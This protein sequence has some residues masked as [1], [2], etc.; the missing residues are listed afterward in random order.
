MTHR[1]AG[2]IPRN[3][4]ML[5]GLRG[6]LAGVE[7]GSIRTKFVMVGV[8]LGAAG[9]IFFVTGARLFGLPALSARVLQ[10]AN[11]VAE[12]TFV[13]DLLM[14]PL[15]LSKK[16]RISV[17]FAIRVSSFV[18]G[19]VLWMF[20]AIVCF[21]F[22][23]YSGLFLGLACLGAGVFPVAF[24]AAALHSQWVLVS[25]LAVEGILTVGA[26]AIG[27]AMIDSALLYAQ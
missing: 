2:I 27:S 14:L 17:G 11:P 10:F 3:D 19:I 21:V 7:V 22:W 24:L 8:A 15:A 1:R 16:L 13:V 6:V 4:E 9:L 12:V 25:A 23:G 18:F 26:W 5:A 20:S